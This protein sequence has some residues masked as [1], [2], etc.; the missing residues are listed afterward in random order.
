MTLVFSLYLL[1]F[2][3]NKGQTSKGNGSKGSMEAGIKVS[4]LL[5]LIAKMS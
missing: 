1:S 3:P 4:N 2:G 5:L